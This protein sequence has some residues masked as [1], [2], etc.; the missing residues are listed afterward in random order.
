[1]AGK[2][3]QHVDAW[4]K[5][6]D[7]T[8]KTED[9][10]TGE[11]RLC[12]D[13]PSENVTELFLV[14]SNVAASGDGFTATTLEHELEGRDHCPAPPYW[15]GTYSGTTRIFTPPGVPN[16]T[17]FTTTFDG[18]LR[19]RPYA[20]PGTPADPDDPTLWQIES[21]TFRI[22]SVAGFIGECSFTSNGKTFTLPG[23]NQVGPVM[24]L[25]AASYHVGVVPPQEVPPLT[26]PVTLVGDPDDCPGEVDWLLDGLGVASLAG[27][28]DPLKPDENGRIGA[29]VHVSEPDRTHNLTFLFTPD[30]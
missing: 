13:K 10:S 26:L 25:V 21:G 7:G 14:S 20:F 11:H 15:N 16:V 24:A 30:S 12:R 2:P 4:L 23:T 3:G 17:D 27:S 22:V 6:A 18:T 29:T 5:L 28:P 19:L 1:M 9:W 8:W